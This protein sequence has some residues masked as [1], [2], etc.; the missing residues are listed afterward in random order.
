[1]GQA[2][3]RPACSATVSA[4]LRD[5]LSVYGVFRGNDR[6]QVAQTLAPRLSACQIRAMDARKVIRERLAD[7]RG[8][9]HKQAP[10]AVALCYPSPYRVGMSSLGFQTIYREINS[11]P[12]R[13]AARAFLPD[14]VAAYAS[15]RTP[16]LTYED[17]APVGD[18]PVIALSV[19]YE[20][21]LA[22]VIQVLQLSGV[23]VLAEERDA[24][25][26]IVLC[27]GP[28]T[29]S[30]PLPLAPFADAIVMG[31]AD[32]AI[33]RVLDAIFGAATR[34]A[35]LRAL[36]QAGCF[37][38][39]LHEDAEL[40]AIEQADNLLLPAWAPIRTP[41]TELSNMFLLEAERGCSRGCQY[42]VMRRSTN[43]GM[44]VIPA[45][46]ILAAIPDDARKVGLV[47]AAVSDHPKIV[48]IIDALAAQ[49]RQVSLSSLRPDRLNDAF[50][51]ALK[52]AG[53]RALTTALDAPSQRLRDRIDRKAKE[54]HFLRI[55]ELVKTH[56]LHH[57]KVYMMV[58]LPDENDADID[59]L[60]AFASELARIHPL[61]I[62]I[63]PF[64]AKRNT[65]LD[66]AAFAGIDVV[67]DRLDRLR[68]GLRGRVD[69]RSTSAR[70]AWVE[71]VLAQGSRAEG[72]AVLDAVRAGG[73]VSH[74]KAAFAAMPEQRKRRAL[75]VVA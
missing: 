74:Y 18:Y 17:G 49:D 63:S 5:F 29:N 73:K 72:L 6:P 12:G 8:T 24:R 28:L 19:A 75:R 31:E 60:I 68:R 61:A 65:P 33:H 25:H 62:G 1:M 39:T 67:E 10:Q 42:C 11:S 58:G 56:K 46:R 26:P 37:V 45:E 53:A 20:I 51:G 4:R 14:D 69:L 21:E 7:E 13:K 9:L 27:G 16:L 3:S 54:K 55:A 70:W 23:P 64:V 38:P 48:Q 59:E 44:R 22:G 2:L 47:G 66:G 57:L 52:R 40:P 71:Y 41:N 35:A 15:S 50:I 32:Q 30:N 43:G 34:D 36:A